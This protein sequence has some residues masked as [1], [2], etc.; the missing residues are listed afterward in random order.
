MKSRK[1]KAEL[2]DETHLLIDWVICAISESLADDLSHFTINGLDILMRC[3]L[4]EKAGKGRHRRHIVI[5]AWPRCVRQRLGSRLLYDQ[6]TAPAQWF[7]PNPS[8][9]AIFA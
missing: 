2:T 8:S 9:G 6:T 5:C 4:C 3:P 7:T 1:L